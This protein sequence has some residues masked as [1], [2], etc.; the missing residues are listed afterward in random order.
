MATVHIGRI[1]V[2]FP[3]SMMNEQSE[4]LYVRVRRA[5]VGALRYG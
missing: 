3:E 1:K 5:T 2:F 4:R